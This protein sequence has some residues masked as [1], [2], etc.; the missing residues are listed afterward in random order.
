[1]TPGGIPM[2]SYMDL[3]PFPPSFSPNRLFLNYFRPY[4]LFV[5]LNTIIDLFFDKYMSQL[6]D[7]TDMDQPGG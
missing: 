6:S 7:D 4:D 2:A 1:M 3:A 5:F